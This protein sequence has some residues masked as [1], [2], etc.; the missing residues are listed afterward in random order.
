MTRSP[1]DTDCL[2]CDGHPTTEDPTTGDVV[3]E[4]PDCEGRGYTLCQ[5]LQCITDRTDD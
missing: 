5:C 1:H 4:C 2:T 3:S